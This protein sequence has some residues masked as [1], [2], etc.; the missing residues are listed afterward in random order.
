MAV[1]NQAINNI[2]VTIVALVEFGKERNV[3][4]CSY[5]Q[6]TTLHRL[7]VSSVLPERNFTTSIDDIINCLSIIYP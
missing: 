6:C 4:S 3:Q 1:I 5:T 7:L 2:A